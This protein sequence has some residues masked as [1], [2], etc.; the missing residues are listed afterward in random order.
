MKVVDVGSGK[1]SAYSSY[2]W[3]YSVA[4]RFFEVEHM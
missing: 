2:L 4:Y 1:N 3:V